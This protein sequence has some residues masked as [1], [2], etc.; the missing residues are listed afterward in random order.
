MKRIAIAIAIAVLAGSTAAHAE[1]EDPISKF[2]NKPPKAEYVSPLGMF[3][4]ERCLIDLQYPVPNVYRQPDR[5][6]DVMIV[7]S[8][9]SIVGV[10]NSRVDLKRVAGG[11]AVKSWVSLEKVS[12]CAPQA[13]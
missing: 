6:D 4:I 9:Q 2:D 7:W 1:Y 10:A 13:R 3:D 12:S 8:G 11:T 5:P